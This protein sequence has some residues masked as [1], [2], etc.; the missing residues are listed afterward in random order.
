MVGQPRLN[1]FNF[2]RFLVGLGT[3]ADKGQ[4]Q[5][6]EQD[7]QNWNWAYLNLLGL[8]TAGYDPVKLGQGLGIQA[9]GTE[10]DGQVQILGH[11]LPIVPPSLVAGLSQMQAKV[12]LSVLA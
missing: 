11:P 7:R 2:Q 8:G 4:H 3:G 10:K 5:D 6:R 12:A 1:P 9:R